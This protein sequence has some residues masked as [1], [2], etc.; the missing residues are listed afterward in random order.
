MIETIRSEDHRGAACGGTP[1]GAAASRPPHGVCVLFFR[2]FSLINIYRY[3][4]YLPVCSCIYSP[5]VP[6]R[7]PLYFPCISFVCTLIYS[8]N[9]ISSLMHDCFLVSASY[10]AGSSVHP[11]IAHKIKQMSWMFDIAILFQDH[12]SVPI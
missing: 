11:Y 2:I 7:F 12:I 8:V 5:N 1:K 10:V 9:S 6:Y 4:L 3:P